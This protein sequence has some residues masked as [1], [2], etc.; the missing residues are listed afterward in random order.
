MF[1]KILIKEISVI[2]VIKYIKK[3]WKVKT[4]YLENEKQNKR[5]K[6]KD[7]IFKPIYINN[8]IDVFRKTKK[9]KDFDNLLSL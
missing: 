8:V 4:I 6:T 1:H 3:G 5:F 2:L 7:I 9:I